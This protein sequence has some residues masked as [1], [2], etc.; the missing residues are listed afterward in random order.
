MHVTCTPQHRKSI[1]ITRQTFRNATNQLFCLQKSPS[2]KGPTQ[3]RTT[4]PTLP[5]YN[6][7]NKIFLSPKL[8]LKKGKKQ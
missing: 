7:T 5:K 2:K 4:N 3:P 6:F 8:S 1:E